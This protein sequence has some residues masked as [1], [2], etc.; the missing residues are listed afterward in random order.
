MEL[1]G[2]WMECEDRPRFIYAVELGELES[3]EYTT[4]AEA[5]ERYDSIQL[6][7]YPDSKYLCVDYVDMHGVYRFEHQVGLE[8]Q[9]I[10]EDGRIVSC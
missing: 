7:S 8:F 10:E 2:N 4:L 5:R 6:E 1:L 3:W 9:Y